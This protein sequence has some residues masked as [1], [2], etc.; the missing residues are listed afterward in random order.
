MFAGE[1]TSSSWDETSSVNVK[2]PKNSNIINSGVYAA[3]HLSAHDR[4]RTPHRYVHACES[5]E[6]PNG[7]AECNGIHAF[8]TDNS[9]AQQQKV[10]RCISIFN[11]CA[12]NVPWCLTRWNTNICVV[13][14]S[15]SLHYS[16]QRFFVH[17]LCCLLFHFFSQF[18]TPRMDRHGSYL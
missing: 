14:V 12:G 9:I 8:C 3:V 13:F 1:K 5:I 7:V 2:P 15:F 17:G 10:S 16:A 11:V 6:W 4:M 18:S